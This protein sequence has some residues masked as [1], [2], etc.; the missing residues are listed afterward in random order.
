MIELAIGSEFMR[1]I[2]ELASTDSLMGHIVGGTAIDRLKENVRRQAI[3]GH[4]QPRATIR[5]FVRVPPLVHRRL[6]LANEK[7]RCP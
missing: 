4:S 1:A 6:A 3:H 5:L 2:R 7:N